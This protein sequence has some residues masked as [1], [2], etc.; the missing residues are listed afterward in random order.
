LLEVPG[1]GERKL[2]LYGGAILKLLTGSEED[3]IPT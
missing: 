3:R 1:F 2:A